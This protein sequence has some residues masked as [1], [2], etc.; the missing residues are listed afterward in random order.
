MAESGYSKI[1]VNKIEHISHTNN[2][3]KD[4]NLH[5]NK[6]N[7]KENQGVFDKLFQKEIDKIT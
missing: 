4:D 1:I 3:K 2:N 6:K 5:N 7:S